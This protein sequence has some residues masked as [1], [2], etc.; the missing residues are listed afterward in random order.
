MLIGG[1]S[2]GFRLAGRAIVPEPNSGLS[3]WLGAVLVL[4]QSIKT[5]TFRRSESNYPAPAAHNTL[6]GAQNG[7]AVS[8][9]LLDPPYN[10]RRW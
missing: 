5:Q 8:L 6:Y 4:C 3:L 7:G 2:S 9:T 10:Q 1:R